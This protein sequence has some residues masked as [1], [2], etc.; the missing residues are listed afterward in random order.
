MA[1][2]LLAKT[3]VSRGEQ[4]LG[5]GSDAGVLGKSNPI[6]SEQCEVKSMI[7]FQEDQASAAAFTSAIWNHK[8]EEVFKFVTSKGGPA[9]HSEVR[10]LYLGAGAGYGVVLGLACSEDNCSHGLKKTGADANSSLTSL[11]VIII[12][13]PFFSVNLTDL[14]GCVS[15]TTSWLL[16]SLRSS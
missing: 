2:H 10:R 5:I 12:A 11:Q 7:D 15:F 4:V 16:C 9:P 3:A 14:R 1:Q 6:L 13:R 8:H